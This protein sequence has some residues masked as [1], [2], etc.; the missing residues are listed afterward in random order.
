MKLSYLTHKLVLR[1]V[2][3]IFTCFIHYEIRFQDGR[4][5]TKITSLINKRKSIKLH[6]FEAI[7]M[8]FERVEEGRFK[9]KKK[10]LINKKTSMKLYDSEATDIEI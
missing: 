1:Y 7:E 3:T 5:K 2:H 9:M 4:F 8:R 10:S 6:D